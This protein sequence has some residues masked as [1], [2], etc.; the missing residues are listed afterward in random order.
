MNLRHRTSTLC[1]NTS[2]F[3]SVGTILDNDAAP[4]FSVDDVSV[5]EGG[6]LVFT[7]TRTGDAQAAQTV[8]NV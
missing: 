5:D 2:L 6:N 1:P 8:D 4:L 7:V 3:R